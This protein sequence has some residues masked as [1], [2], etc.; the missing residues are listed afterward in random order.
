[1]DKSYNI[2]CVKSLK[3][4]QATLDQLCIKSKGFT[5]NI[6][7]ENFYEY[8]SFLNLTIEWLEHS[9]YEV[10]ERVRSVGGIANY[11][12]KDITDMSQIDDEKSM[13]TDYDDMLPKLLKGYQTISK[14]ACS[15]FKDAAANADAGTV[16]LMTCL[17]GKA[18]HYA[19]EIG[20]MIDGKD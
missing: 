3:E 4:I 18:D 13:S 16:G 9:S 7:S 2:K 20:A 8:H 17:A 6:L 14:L 12:L 10:A 5:Y 19:W 15:L 1:M 11:S